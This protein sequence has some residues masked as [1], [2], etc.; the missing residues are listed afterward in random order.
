MIQAGRGVRT[1]MAVAL[2]ALG[3]T[4]LGALA[5]GLAAPAD[6][7]LIGSLS[8]TV[9][10]A[11]RPLPQAWV[12]VTPVHEDGAAAGEPT[13]V[14]TDSTGRYELPEV[15]WRAV[16]VQARAP[17]LGE[18]VD[19]YWPD[20]HSFGQA[21]IVQISSWPVTADIDLPRGG[22]VQGTVVDQETGAAVPGARVSAWMVDALTAGPVGAQEAS[23]DPGAFRLGRLPPVAVRL[24]VHLPADST[25]LEPAFDLTYPR[26]T[27]RIDGARRTVD[28]VIALL[29]GAEIRGTVRDDR[30][31]PVAGAEVQI[32]RCRPACPPH[33]FTD[34][35]GRYRIQAIPPG[36]DLRAF[37]PGGPSLLPQWFRGAETVFTATPFVLR[38][39]DVR[40]D[41][42]FEVT[43]GGFANVRVL[44]AD[45][46]APLIGAIVTLVSRTD[47]YNRHLGYGSPEDPSNQRIG[48]VPPGDY[49]LSV[50][51]GTSNPSYLP[52][53]GYTDLV[54]APDGIVTLVGGQT[55]DLAVRLPAR[56]G[57]GEG[58]AL[59]PEDAEPAASG[60]P[61]WPGL[62]AGFRAP[63]TWP[64]R[65][66]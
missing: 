13:R 3:L 19:T 46:G 17:G 64:I 2:I 20:A 21:G 58:R 35:A 42:D 28:L 49:V 32:T 5:P 44:A 22:S 66:G 26:E 48:P 33:A 10:G 36:P 25:L 52:V 31:A 37:T 50:R 12:V 18:L 11:G 57:D 47:L 6:A 55:R 41:V 54:L 30:G 14:L 29:P 60:S 24:A 59:D 62:D 65:T 63:P 27:L 16:K 61:L 43:R 4:A 15:Y 40:A 34:D 39:G 51:P 38:S 1:A 56:G 45:T 53:T 9:T 8:G 23:G 7:T